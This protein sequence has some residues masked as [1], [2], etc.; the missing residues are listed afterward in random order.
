MT[1]QRLTEKEQ[2]IWLLQHYATADGI[3]NLPFALRF[4]GG[5]EPH[6]LRDA[7]NNLPRRHAALRTL[8]PL[9]D[10]LPERVV[11]PA[12]EVPLEIRSSAPERLDDELT[13]FA[14]RPFDI[15]AE[16]PIR[17]ALIRMP[18]ADVVCVV[19][20]HIAA[21]A[22][23]LGV[24]QRELLATLAADG[25]LPAELRSEVVAPDQ[26][27][28]HPASR[29]YWRSQ[30]AGLGPRARLRVG[31]PGARDPGLPGARLN[32]RLP[33]A[34]SL[35]I[36]EFAGRLRVT[37][38]ILMFAAYAATLSALGTERTVL[39]GAPLHDRGERP[40]DAVG[41]HISVVPLRLEAA[42]TT[43]FTQLARD[44]RNTL[45]SGLA[46]ARVPVEESAPG[47]YGQSPHVAEPLL[48]HMFNVFEDLS[49]MTAGDAVAEAVPVFTGYSRMELELRVVRSERGLGLDVVYAADVFR[50][51]EVKTILDGLRELVREADDDPQR[52]IGELAWWKQAQE[53]V[54]TERPADVARRPSARPAADLALVGRLVKLWQELLQ[55]PGLDAD[56]DFFASGGTSLLA[57][58]LIFKIKQM[59]NRS[60]SLQTVLEA[61]T[62][63]ALAA[64]LSAPEDG[65]Y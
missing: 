63:V 21:D 14:A 19:L 7:L 46:H 4:S 38:N 42:E 49:E 28:A 44:A 39:V 55:R 2:A 8:F 35:A 58:Q 61:P 15:A 50:P 23:S 27:A 48:R 62:P 30:L 57:A 65:N 40:H 32:I 52:P 47:S 20:H 60:V 3:T 33:A 6:A 11:Q 56:T 16:P 64:I 25:D 9:V 53:M 59:G 22:H 29:E 18:G 43:T 34:E 26:P 41:L 31:R 10:G 54:V 5:V 37:V 24:V 51:A 12:G 1:D 45:L 17:A 13:H 36:A